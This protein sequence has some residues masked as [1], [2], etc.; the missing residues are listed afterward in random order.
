VCWV[1]KKNEPSASCELQCLTAK[2]SF[3]G[4]TIIKKIGM[5]QDELIF[6]SEIMTEKN[7]KVPYLSKQQPTCY[8]R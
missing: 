3:I 4:S 6:M 8:N 2:T 1:D 5:P 7:E